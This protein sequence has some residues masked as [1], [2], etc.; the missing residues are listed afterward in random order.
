MLSVDEYC[1]LILGSV[2]RLPHRRVALHDALGCV[3]AEQVLA[4]F[5]LPPFASSAMDGFAVRAADIAIASEETPAQLAVVG[6]VSMGKAPGS[7]L[8]RGE[9]IAIPTG[10]VVPEGADAIVPNELVVRRGGH[11]LVFGPIPQG[12]HVRPAG[13][14]LARG[15]VVVDEGSTLSAA[16]LGALAASGTAEVTVVPRAKVGILSTGDELVRPAGALRAGQIYD[17]NAFMLA[18]LVREAGAQPIDLGPL[19]DDPEALVSALDAPGAD[20]DAF[21]CSGGVSAGKNDPVKGAFASGSEVCCV[22]VAVQPGRPQAFGIRQGKPF[23]GVPG[24]PVAAFVSFE[25]F[26]RPGLCKM[27]GR[28]ERRRAIEATLDGTVKAPEDCVRF[29]MAGLRREGATLIATPRAGQHSNLLA[30]LARADALVEVPPGSS[31]TSG[32]TCRIRPIREIPGN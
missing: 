22:D 7:S 30:A 27:M 12:R 15:E 2:T 28:A 18:G 31:I 17:S 32:M 8:E 1:D 14:D 9:A 24:N 20:V 21:I 29:V 16:D 4:E 11:I 10:A 3:L 6:E 25:L 5:D 13:E 23:F 26:V 19:P